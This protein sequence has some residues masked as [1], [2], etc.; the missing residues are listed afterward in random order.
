MLKI[1]RYTSFINVIEEL[2]KVDENQNHP[3]RFSKNNMQKGYLRINF[4]SEVIGCDLICKITSISITDVKIDN[5]YD[6]I[7]SK[8][9]SGYTFNEIYDY[10]GYTSLIVDDK[11]NSDVWEEH[12]M[13]SW[14]I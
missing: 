4:E 2:R 8:I 3:I 10:I 9:N 5:I 7:T 14:V 6:S 1:G 12:I 11:F 13:K